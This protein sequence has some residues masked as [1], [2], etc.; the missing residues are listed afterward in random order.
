MNQSPDQYKAFTCSVADV[1]AINK[2]PSWHDYALCGIFGVQQECSLDL[3]GLNIAV[4]GQ[5][6]PGQGLSSSSALVCA[7][8]LATLCLHGKY[9]KS[10][11]ERNL[12]QV[13]ANSEKYVGTQGGGMDQAACLLSTEGCAQLIS[14]NPLHCDPVTLPTGASFVVAS[15]L[16]SINKAATSHFNCRVVEGRIACQ[17]LAKESGLNRENVPNLSNLQKQLGK[18]LDEMLE[19]VDRSFHEEPYTLDEITELLGM[20]AEGIKREI[21]SENT[22]HLAQFQLKRRARHVF[23]EARRVFRFKEICDTWQTNASQNKGE[24]PSSKNIMTLVFIRHLC[25]V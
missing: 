17:I 6:P 3:K 18:S 2:P 19:L 15:S 25:L 10:S 8:A 11:C 16:S 7:G 1:G 22:Q 5:I 20:S 9:K 13:C 24:N 14:F 12:A 23:S 4:Q 21:L